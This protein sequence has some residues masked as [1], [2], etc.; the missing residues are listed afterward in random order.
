MTLEAFLQAIIA[1]PRNAADTWLVL[2]DW[3]EEQDDSR[4]ELVRLLH[5]HDYRRS[6]SPEQ[7]DAR[8]CELL[9]SGVGPVAPTIENSIGM[10]FALIPAGVFLMGS[11]ESEAE[12]RDDE[13]QREVEITHRFFLGVHA[14]TQADYQRIM[15]ENP[16]HFS[17]KGGGKK[18]VKKLR[19]DR[20]PV[21]SVSWEDATAFCVKLSERAEETTAGRSYRLPTEAEWE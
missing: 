20:F 8:L 6:L 15:G 21:E 5:H 11:P 18:E 3:L 2:A 7:P 9:A 13:T 4:Y 19:T 16:S 1:D 17:A 14:V 12:R 10:R